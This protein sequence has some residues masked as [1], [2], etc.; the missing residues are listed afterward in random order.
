MVYLN[1]QFFCIYLN[2]LHEDFKVKC[3]TGAG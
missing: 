2:G 1:Y 3:E